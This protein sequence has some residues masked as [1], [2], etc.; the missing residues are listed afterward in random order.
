MNLRSRVDR[1]LQLGLLAVVDGQPLHE[2]RGEARAGSTAEGVEDE[3][4]LEAGALVSD[5][6]D[7]VQ[8][9]VDDLLAC[10]I[11]TNLKL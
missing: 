6:A 1:E 11:M 3:E 10:N 5:L 9:E 4:A 8:N 7:T 2:Q